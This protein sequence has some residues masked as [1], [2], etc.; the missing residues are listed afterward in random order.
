MD[1][2]NGNATA[3]ELAA[4]AMETIERKEP[5]IRAFITVAER[6][7][8]AAEEVDRKIARGEDAGSLAGLPIAIKDNISVKG[9]RNTC[10]SRMLANYVPPYNATVVDKLL[11][12]GAVI[13]GKTTMD[14]FAMGSST[15]TCFFGPARNPWDVSRVPGGSS[16]GSAAAVASG[17]VP[18]ALGSDT[19]G[20]ARCPA[21]FTGTVGLKPTYGRVSRW[22]LVSYSHSLEQISPIAPDVLGV[23]AL[24]GAIAGSDGRD[25]TSAEVEVPSYVDEATAEP[26]RFRVGVVKE[27][28][29]EG[30]DERVANLVYGA[31]EKVKEAGGS[32]EQVSIPCLRYALPT[33]YL[34]AMSECS[35]NLSRFDGLRYGFHLDAK[36]NE[37]WDELFSRTR[38]AGFGD[39][40][41]RRIILGTFALSAGYYDEWFVKA[42]KVRTL[43]IRDFLRA[44]KSFD[45]LA[46][47]TMPCLPWK[48]G[49][50]A[51]PLSVYRMDVDTV[52]VNLAG[53]PAI[54]LPAGLAGGL[55]AGL[56][57][58]GRHF[59]EPFLLRVSYAYEQITGFPKNVP[60]S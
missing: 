34:I 2:K 28:F 43:V 24:L 56:Q 8:E 49:E 12:Q 37:G 17:E 57:L 50:L 42:A 25:A 26:G 47:P 20:S 46:G 31:L 1:V 48:V 55:P 9:M 4:R 10:G 51:D 23:A 45:I 38:A 40:V 15:E 27:F 19:G 35:S 13:C 7:V 44:F 58:I 14:E 52:A 59:E 30:T 53:L 3:A 60:V 21:A 16:G 11:A 39:E 18:A 22:G 5:L 29:G 54:S 36:P 6:A 41:K 32:L 33:Y